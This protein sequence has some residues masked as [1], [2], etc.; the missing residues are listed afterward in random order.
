MVDEV[1]ERR[2]EHVV[3]SAIELGESQRSRKSVTDMDVTLTVYGRFWQ[4]RL[5]AS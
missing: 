3:Y 1:G 4:I 2:Y 5:I